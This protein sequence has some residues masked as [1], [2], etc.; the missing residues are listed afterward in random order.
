MTFSPYVSGISLVLAICI[1]VSWCVGGEEWDDLNVLQLNTEKPHASMM[2][3]HMV[4]PAL[5]GD[6]EKSPWFKSLNGEW[7]FRWSKNP[8]SRPAEFFKVGFKDSAWKTIPVPSNWQVHGYGTPIYTNIKYPHPKNPP[9]A[10]REYNP[11]GSYRTAFT[12]P[13]DWKGRKVLIHFAG[14]DS[15]FYLWINGQKVGYSQGSRTPAEFD[16]TKYLKDGENLLAVEVYRWCE[17]SYLEDQ[18]FWRL[19]GIFRDVYLWSRDEVYIRDFRVR[20]DLDDQYKDATLSLDVEL[21]G[22]T[23]GHSVQVLL[24]DD[25]NKSVLT[26]TMS[27]EA[28]GTRHVTRDTISAPGLWSA[29][30]PTLYQLL[31]ILKKSNNHVVEVIPCRVG[32]REVEIRN[33]IFMVNGVA[34]KMKGVNR[35]ETEPDTGHTVTLEGMIKDIKLFKQFNVN[36]VRTCHYPDDPLF[37]SL[38]DEYGIYVMDEANIE[39]HDA[40][41]L[42]G[43]KEWVPAQ[44]NRVRRMAE[45]DKNH[46]SIVIWSLGNEAGKGAGPQAMYAWLNREHPDRPVHCEYDN[47]PADVVSRMYAGPGW[48][49]GGTGKPSVLCEYT[50]AMGNSNGNLKEYWDHIYANKNHM[51]A[52]VWDWVDQG[53]RQPL[54]EEFKKRVGTGP[55]KDTFFAYGGWWE[56]AEKR[57]HDDNFCMN[58]LVSSDRV[59]HPGL[60]AI[61][62]AYRNIHVS[63]VDVTAGRFKVR[64]WFDHSNIKDKAEGKW[65]L[66]GNGRVVAEGKIPE[67]DVAPHTE[68]GFTI[69]LPKIQRAAGTEYLLT[70]S[71]AAKA[72]YSP[73]INPG[74]EIAWEQ[75]VYADAIATE[76]DKS[77]Q[78]EIKVDDGDKAVS[79]NGKDFTVSFNKGNG[80]LTAFTHK[81]KKLV[82]RG[83]K[84]DFWRA[85]TD[86]DRPSARRFADNRWRNAGANWR[87]HACEVKTLEGGAVRVLFSAALSGVSAACRLLYT[88]YG[89]GQIEVAMTCAPGGTG[90][91]GPLRYGLEMLLPESMNLVQYYGRGPNPTYQD[92][93]FERIGMFE[94]TVDGM[95]VDYSEPQENGYRSD[96]RWVALRDADQGGLLFVG[97]PLICFGAKHYAQD[98]IDK[99]KYS[100]QMERSK[101]IH[102]NV[103]LVQA[104]VGGNNSWGATPLRQYQLKSERVSY[105]FR[106]IP[107]GKGDDVDAKLTR[108]PVSHPIESA[109]PETTAAVPVNT[110]VAASSEETN[111][112]NVASHLVDDD[113]ATRW[114]ASDA[115]MP[116]WVSIRLDKKQAVKQVRIAWEEKGLYRY[117]VDGSVD[118]KN[119]QLLADRSKNTASGQTTTDALKGEAQFIRI[120]ILGAPPECWA[121]IYEVSVQ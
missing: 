96:V 115:S 87:V 41:Q 37:Y 40:R 77:Q 76:A 57:H 92:R 93:K 49:G 69:N 101:S 116:Q 70:L 19:A 20:T 73:L 16:I 102:L 6:P 74:H 51:G 88:V 61:K 46:A 59:P 4:E 17:G 42:S 100:F 28:D 23:K 120:T 18:D 33:G 82:D 2:S 36:A 121:S 90:M 38:C 78:P 114:C 106:M 67:L 107:L 79:I 109:L 112:G 11:V 68:K 66:L 65:E 52:Y 50:H 24:L 31:L 71:F 35:H 14:V 89:D 105:R 39:C 97:D 44:M 30:S 34:V 91:K 119:W 53:I 9:K 64:N 98:V 27:R 54:P 55:V 63:A 117:R 85:T 75:Y 103:D 95:W 8:A 10:P 111:K 48:L 5:A 43:M 3:F 29:E 118:G 60:F 113:A 1:M 80:L 12:V 56:D 83:F 15:A 81:G 99:A 62:Y 110:R 32:F 7:K 25:A 86:N 94:A 45:R 21:A 47:G 108:R 84:P 104:G 26:K 22:D 58:G 72:G 13:A